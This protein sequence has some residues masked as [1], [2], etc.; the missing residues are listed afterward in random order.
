MDENE[1]LPCRICHE[2]CGYIET[3]GGWCL[4][5]VCGN[6]G[7]TTAFIKYD[8]DEEKKE[9]EKQA[10]WLWNMGKVIAERRGE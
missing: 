1:L 9:A 8:N 3:E 2:D 10:A 4:Y 7:S 5:A 6:C